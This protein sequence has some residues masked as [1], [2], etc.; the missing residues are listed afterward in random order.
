[1]Y[2]LE[3][4]TYRSFE[5]VFE[6]LYGGTSSSETS[7][8]STGRTYS[9]ISHCRNGQAD[10]KFGLE[11]RY[12]DLRVT[13]KVYDGEI[14]SRNPDRFWIGKERELDITI[15]RTSPIMAK[16]DQVFLDTTKMLQKKGAS[17]KE[18]PRRF[19]PY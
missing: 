10:R 19:R 2:S 12:N 6:N 14:S 4:F 7:T 1:M 18:S 11:E 16:V 9:Y 5:E 15:P 17:L 13:V 3:L 8:G